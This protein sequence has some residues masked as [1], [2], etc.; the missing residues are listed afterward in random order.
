MALMSWVRSF[1]LSKTA[2]AQTGNLF[3]DRGGNLFQDRGGI[4]FMDKFFQM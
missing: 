4:S 1:K 3:Q 2:R